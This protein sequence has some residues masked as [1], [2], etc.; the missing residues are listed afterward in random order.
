GA[1]GK[2]AAHR[3]NLGLADVTLAFQ[4]PTA[5]GLAIN[6]GVISGGGFIEYDERTGRYAGARDLRAG[7]VR[8]AGGGVLEAPW[9]DRPPPHSLLVFLT[10]RFPG[11]ELGLGIALTGIGGLLALNRR[12]DIDAFAAR[13]AT[14]TAG[15]LLALDD[16]EVNAPLILADLGRCSHRPTA[17]S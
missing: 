17:S 1:R 4:P 10:A 9:P 3:G 6:A 11:I 5:L 15:R 16:P 8:V 7:E 2:L 12:L 14:G 13:F